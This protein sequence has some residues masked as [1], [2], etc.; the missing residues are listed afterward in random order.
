MSAIKYIIHY[1]INTDEGRNFALS[2]V[3]K[4]NYIIE[5]LAELGYS[6]EIISASLI[7]SKKCARGSKLK[8]SDKVSLT[9]LPAVKS[10]GIIGKIIAH[11]W[12][13][14]ALLIYLLFNTHK[15]DTVIVYH[16]LSLINI[17]KCIKKIKRINLILEAEEVYTNASKYNK[18]VEKKEIKYFN[19]ADK[20]LFSTEKLNDK[21]NRK[22]KL[23]AIDYGTYSCEK[24]RNVSFGNDKVHVLYA[25]T[26]DPRKGGASAAASAAE[27][28]SD[29]YHIHILG[30]GSAEEV[31]DIKSLVSCVNQKSKATVTYDGVL[32][33][34]DFIKFMQKCHIGLSTQNPDADFN[35]TS[36]PSKIL[37][38]MAN[39][40]R[41]VT[42]KIPVI[43][44]SKINKA[45]YYYEKQT[46]QEIAKAIET[47]DF[48]DG[49]D[50]RKKI[51]KLDLEFKENLR[52]LLK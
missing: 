47:V 50:G 14:I 10:K 30:F 17:I 24:D 48:C 16:S 28:L 8:L 1:D 36:F 13:K 31:K 41:V 18:K 27:F 6:V 19:I 12:Q 3:N 26:L 49:Y 25:G 44:E 2:A 11:I 7:S 39:G 40:L 51:K 46:P 37:S 45:M 9:K 29:N 42:I 5:T 38:Y 21:F 20:Y 15:G 4:A 33:G 23:Y 22:N 52:E 32:F 34:E 43:K 35:D